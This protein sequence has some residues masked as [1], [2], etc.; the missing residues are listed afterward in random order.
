M[1]RLLREAVGKRLLLTF[2]DEESA[3]PCDW[4][5]ILEFDG[6]WAQVEFVKKKK[7]GRETRLIPISDIHTITLLPERGEG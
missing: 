2:Y 1:T 7:D 6:G 4:C 3:I 5:R